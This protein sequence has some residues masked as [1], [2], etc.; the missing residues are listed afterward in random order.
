M[1]WITH[2]LHVREYDGIIPFTAT[3][4]ERRFEVMSFHKACE[5]R[6]EELDALN[7]PLYLGIS[8]GADS[9]YMWHTFERMGIPFTPILVMTTGNYPEATWALELLENN[10]KT[11]ILDVSDDTL[12]EWYTKITNINSI[13]IHSVPVLVGTEYAEKRDGIFLAADHLWSR[14]KYQST[15]DP[16][17]FWNVEAQE[18]EFYFQFFWGNHHQ[19]FFHTPEIHYAALKEIKE[20]ETPS[21][22]KA[23]L[24]GTEERPKSRA[25]YNEA[26]TMKMRDL[27][28]HTTIVNRR[29]I[30]GHTHNI[31]NI[32]ETW[33]D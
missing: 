28:T 18:W 13:G 16:N 6:A 1:N 21:A 22:F 27:E 25:K 23:R 26:V 15:K 32:M 14:N 31:I 29:A 12:L 8:G 3:M 9:E 7:I 19:L 20:G 4:N 5:K 10:D 30:F 33:N 24:Y 11:V 17:D 2:N